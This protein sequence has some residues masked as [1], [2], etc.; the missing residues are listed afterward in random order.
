MWQHTNV[1]S[2]AQACKRQGLWKFVFGS[3]ELVA[4][5]ELREVGYKVYDGN[6]N[7][8]V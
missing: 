2:E 7:R 1:M 8:H 5:S 6:G 4:F 3:K